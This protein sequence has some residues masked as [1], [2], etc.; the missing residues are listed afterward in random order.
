M[1]KGWFIIL[2]FLFVG[3]SFSQ[4]EKQFL[5]AAEEAFQSFEYSEAIYFYEQAL[6]FKVNDNSYFQIGLCHMELKDYE[7]AVLAFN[8]IQHEEKFE[9]LAYYQGLTTQFLGDYNKAISHFKSFYNTYTQDDFYKLK[10]AQSISACYWAMDQKNNEEIVIEH[11]PKP[12]NTAYSDFSGGYLDST[13]FYVSTYQLEKTVEDYL[14][15]IVFY[16]SENDKFKIDRTISDFEDDEFDFANGYYLEETQEFYYTK[17]FS[18]SLGEKNCDIYV[19]QFKENMWSDAIA[20]SFNTKQYTET[21]PFVYINNQQEKVIYFVSNRDEGIGKNDIWMSIANENGIFKDLVCLPEEINTIDD[22]SS[23]FYDKEQNRFYFSSKWHYGFGGY[24]IFSSQLV[25]G[26]Y[27]HPENLGLPI[28]SSANDQYYRL[29]I[30]E[31]ALFASN[32]EGAYQLKKSACCYDIF[33][34]KI[35]QNDLNPDTLFAMDET[36]PL[37]NIDTLSDTAND[38]SSYLPVTV[39]FHNDEP[40]PKTTKDKTNLS[41]RDCYDSY[42][43]LQDEYVRE[44]GEQEVIEEW[45]KQVEEAYQY[46]DEFLVQVSEQLKS[47]NINLVIEG[48]CSPLALNDYNIHLA[49]RRIVSLENYILQWEN[50]RLKKAFDNGELTFDAAPFGEEKADSNI[51]DSVDDVKYSIYD[52]KAAVERRV[53]IIAVVF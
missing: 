5:K 6:Q 11:F 7:N 52:P 8:N 40:N 19:R 30:S 35:H 43:L 25:D 48:Y 2:S 22:E 16:Q 41:Y 15:S 1:K 29:S 24:D 26:K 4:T 42:M 31:K 23:P 34:H 37:L 38:L 13:L 27:Q 28:N 51:S 17:C 32:R 46:L 47:Q 36:T 33:A 39:Y 9:K 10:A 53:A 49:N 45:F 50:S 20:L 44:F 18:D 12:V 21:Q 3:L 14:S